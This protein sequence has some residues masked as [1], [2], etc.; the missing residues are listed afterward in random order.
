LFNE[1]LNTDANALK[2][3]MIMDSPA[4][5]DLLSRIERTFDRYIHYIFNSGG[6]RGRDL[7]HPDGNYNMQFK[8]EKSKIRGM[9]MKMK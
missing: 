9:R 7:K 2:N 8:S 6:V 1:P 4:F 3:Y 5:E